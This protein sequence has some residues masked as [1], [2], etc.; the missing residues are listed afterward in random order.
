MRTPLVAAIRTYVRRT[1]DVTTQRRILSSVCHQ[2]TDPAHATMPFS[3]FGPGCSGGRRVL[4]DF[5]NDMRDI[6]HCCEQHHPVR[7]DR[8]GFGRQRA[9]RGFHVGG[10]VLLRR[11]RVKCRMFRVNTHKTL[12]HNRLMR[13]VTRLEIY[14]QAN[15]RQYTPSTV[16]YSISTLKMEGYSYH[17]MYLLALPAIIIFVIETPTTASKPSSCPDG[18]VVP[19]SLEA[20][21]SY[22]V[23]IVSCVSR[24]QRCGRRRKLG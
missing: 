5:G 18:L 15:Y 24:M 11:L 7:A 14:L 21:P 13:R 23:V 22:N 3:F 4:G 9:R 6:S 20:G 19:L 17:A 16:N 8:I 10:D 2:P 1:Y 12:L